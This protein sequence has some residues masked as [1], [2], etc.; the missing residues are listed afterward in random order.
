MTEKL[1]SGYR[2][3]FATPSMDGRYEK[4]YARALFETFVALEHHG[5]QTDWVELPGCS[6]LPFARAKIFG[7]FLRSGW[8]H[9]MMIDA[10]MGWEVA[11]ILRM[12]LLKKDFVAGA[13]MK[14]KFPTEFAYNTCDKFGNP[15]PSQME[16]DSGLLNVSEVGMAFTL[17]S[18]ECAVRMAA[19]Y[20]DLE[21]D[22]QGQ[23]EHHVFLPFI[24]P[25]TK[26]YLPEDFAFCYR[27]RQIGG[28]IQILPSIRLSHIGRYNWQGA[29][30]DTFPQEEIHDV[31]ETPERDV[32]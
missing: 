15:V 24:V 28:K 21:F 22:V 16:M 11:D 18:R 14:K 2:I 32:A 3:Q 30:S 27:W 17:I 9:L 25:G 31:E 7:N 4:E 20:N 10:D 23:I 13:G 6:D 5:A 19:H 29:I 1:L 26:R 12:I 8:T